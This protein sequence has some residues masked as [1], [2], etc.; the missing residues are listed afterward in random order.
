MYKYISFVSAQDWVPIR[1][2][3]QQPSPTFDSLAETAPDAESPGSVPGPGTET[4]G[5]EGSGSTALDP[6]PADKD[7]GKEPL[8]YTYKHVCVY[9]NIYIY[10]H[11]SIYLSIYII[12]ID[13]SSYESIYLCYHPTSYQ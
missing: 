4:K 1:K 8:A 5:A 11:L 2:P 10:M 3:P 6:N 7:I 12:S 9:L 13:I